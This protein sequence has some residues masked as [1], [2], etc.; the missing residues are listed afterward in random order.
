MAFAGLQ[1]G[2]V[3]LDPAEDT[4]G[5]VQGGQLST[6]VISPTLDGEE[7]SVK[8]TDATTERLVVDLMIVHHLSSHLFLTSVLALTVT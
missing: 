7:S 5:Q 8:N 2:G 3:L 4:D 1:E 6:P